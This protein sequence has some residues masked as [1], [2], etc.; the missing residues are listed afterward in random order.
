[1][2]EKTHSEGALAFSCSHRLWSGWNRSN[3]QR[4]FKLDRRAVR[5]GRVDQARYVADAILGFGIRA[6]YAEREKFAA[7]RVRA[8]SAVRGPAP[9]VG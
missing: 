8:E 1:M 2:P 4:E 5:Q 6:G 7:S 3:R 9:A